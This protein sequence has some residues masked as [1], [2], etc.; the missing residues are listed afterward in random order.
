[1]VES[2]STPSSPPPSPLLDLAQGS[3]E[4]DLWVILLSSSKYYYN[5]RHLANCLTIYHIVRSLGVSDDH[6]ILLDAADVLNDERNL[7]RGEI[8]FENPMFWPKEGKRNLLN[9]TRNCRKERK[10]S[11]TKDSSWFSPVPHIENDYEV[12]YRGSEVTISLFSDLLAS[13]LPLTSSSKLL[14]YLTGHG[15]NEFFKF[16]DFEEMDL[17]FFLSLLQSLYYHR[18]YSEILL[19]LDTCQAS[20]MV[21]PLLEKIPF[22][23]VVASSLKDENSYSYY[24]HPELAVPLIDRFTFSFYNFFYVNY[25][26]YFEDENREEPDRI[27]QKKKKEETKNRSSFLLFP[28]PSYSL[29]I[30]DLFRSLDPPFLSSTPFIGKPSRKKSKSKSESKESGT[31]EELNREESA[32]K[33][34]YLLDFFSNKRYLKS[35]PTSEMS[36]LP[37]SAV[38][39]PLSS[40]SMHLLLSDKVTV[41]QSVKFHQDSEVVEEWKASV[42]FTFLVF[43][44][45]SSASALP[46]EQ[47]ALFLSYISS[48]RVRS[49]TRMVENEIYEPGSIVFLLLLLTFCYLCLR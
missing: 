35:L 49:Q 45:M 38:R 41:R 27:R 48:Y 14:F 4:E 26:F 42:P 15:G 10:L 25:L 22:L 33:P 8:F 30:D 43:S 7:Y 5:Y 32:E 1:M 19:I 18:R 21:A 47:D 34:L 29:T 28:E 2:S 39:L 23:N 31:V 20:T 11:E 9:F 16:S 40:S 46:G 6:I 36:S 3:E 44:E 24:P 37:S 13:T 17:S 12:D